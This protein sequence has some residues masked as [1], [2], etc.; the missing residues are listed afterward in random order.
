M[1]GWSLFTII[2]TASISSLACIF[3]IT[4]IAC[5]GF[6]AVKS[7]QYFSIGGFFSVPDFS[8]KLIAIA[9]M[10]FSH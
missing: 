5:S 3:S 2:Q 4:A 1:F 7:T 6:T 8:T 9:L 10:F